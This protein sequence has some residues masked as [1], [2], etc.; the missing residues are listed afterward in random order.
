[1]I[2]QYFTR[3]KSNHCRLGRKLLV[4]LFALKT[5]EHASEFKEW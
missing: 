3:S 2:S 4:L 5:H 1:M